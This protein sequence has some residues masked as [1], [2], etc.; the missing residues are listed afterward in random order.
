MQE[1]DKMDIAYTEKNS[2]GIFIS[3]AKRT[4]RNSGRAV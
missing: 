4:S 3:T 2:I 1:E